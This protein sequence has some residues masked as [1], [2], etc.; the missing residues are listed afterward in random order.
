RWF[1]LERLAQPPFYRRFLMLDWDHNDARPVDWIMGCC[2]MV[3]QAAFAKTVGFDESFFLY[4]EDIDLCRR[5]Y[6]RQSG[7]GL[8]N[9]MTLIHVASILR[10]RR[11]HG[12]AA[13]QVRWSPV[14]LLPVLIVG[15]LAVTELAL[16]VGRYARL[17]LPILGAYP[18]PNPSP[19][20]GVIYLIVPLIW[21]AVFLLLGLYNPDRLKR[22]IR[23]PGK[24][25]SGVMVS[26][27]VL[28]GSLYALFLSQVYIPRLLLIYFL[29]ADAALLLGWR[30]LLH[31]ILSRN[32]LIY[33]P[34][35]L[36]VGAAD[37]AENV[38][39]WINADSRPPVDL[40]G[41][42]PWPAGDDALAR[43]GYIEETARQLHIEAAILTPPFPS[44][45]TISTT[46]SALQKYGVETKVIPDSLDIDLNRARYE[47]LY[48]LTAI[49][50]QP[51][52][53]EGAWRI[54]GRLLGVLR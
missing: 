30:Q 50:I 10:Y 27:L 32:G 46:V 38:V 3:R 42:I 16:Q 33:R 52:A 6:R 41:A 36:L 11:K 29:L 25:L 1:K 26:G 22:S 18:Y 49:N 20:R 39:R 53:P 34:R 13:G 28:A 23:A 4:Y 44:R 12:M 31:Q 24:L 43:A 5:M 9:S 7:R 54:I 37:V 14:Y 40:I 21:L 17:W 35:A 19:L 48:G 8:L 45:E 2:M 47:T 51:S 15:D